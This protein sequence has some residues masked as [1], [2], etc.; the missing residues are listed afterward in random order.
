[1]ILTPKKSYAGPSKGQTLWTVSQ[2]N[3]NVGYAMAELLKGAYMRAGSL[4]AVTHQALGLTDTQA[5]DEVH[6][7]KAIML[8]HDVAEGNVKARHHAKLDNFD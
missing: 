3:D 4:V 1:M 8:I 5:R 6:V 2:I 7:R